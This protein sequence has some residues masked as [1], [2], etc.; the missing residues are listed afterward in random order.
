MRYVLI[1][2]MFL[3]ISI[4]C[5]FFCIG[6]LG[7]KFSLGRVVFLGI[8]RWIENVLFVLGW[9]FIL[10]VLLCCFIR[11]LVSVRLMLVFCLLCV[12]FWENVLKICGRNFELIFVL[13]FVSE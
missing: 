1:V 10:I 12:L 2:G 13:L 6:G 7:G 8:G 9:L 11:V 3:V 5:W 4:I